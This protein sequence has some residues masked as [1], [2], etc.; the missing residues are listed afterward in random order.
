MV[1]ELVFLTLST[2]FAQKAPVCVRPKDFTIA[3]HLI[4][5]ERCL[6]TKKSFCE[7][8]PKVTECPGFL[9]SLKAKVAAS[10]DPNQIIP[11]ERCQVQKTGYY[12]CQQE[13]FHLI[14]KDVAKEEATKNSPTPSSSPV[15][16]PNEA[17]SD[18]T[19]LVAPPKPVEAQ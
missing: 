5:Y 17:T 8:N 14:L 15:P 11:Q 9:K 12:T 2:A 1:T 4:S 7:K 19:E 6:E 16:S 13:P 18:P 3:K 10:Q